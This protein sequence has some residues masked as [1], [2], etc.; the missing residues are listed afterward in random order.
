MNET[1]TTWRDEC[2]QVRARLAEHGL[3]NAA[4]EARWL[5]E[6]ASGL[7]GA[8][9]DVDDSPVGARAREHLW[10]MCDRRIAGEPLQYVLGSWSFRGLDLMVD[11]RVLIPRPETEWVVEVALREM[12]RRGVRRGPPAASRRAGTPTVHVADLGTGSG[13][14]ALAL[15]AE[16]PDAEIWATDVSDDALA[17]ARA[18]LAGQ[19]STL[20]RLAAGSWFDALPDDLRGRLDL[21]VSNPP[22][23]A[24]DERATLVPEVRDREPAVALFAGP[25]GLEA[26]EVVIGEAPAWLRPGGVLVC[27][28]A[29]HQAPPAAAAARSAGYESVTV[30]DDLAGRARVLVAATPSSDPR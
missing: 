16:L 5:V 23:L 6:A 1:R 19:A 20:V 25:S 11:P 2:A 4:R 26:L 22:Y 9:L 7:D 17:V 8:E 13:A 27:E 29:P 30:H 14:I 3:A 18:N 24:D 10:S 12:E 28:L 15:A 21:V